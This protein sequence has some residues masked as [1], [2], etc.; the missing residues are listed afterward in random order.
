VRLIPT[1]GEE[2]LYSPFVAASG[3][4]NLFELAIHQ[5]CSFHNLTINERSAVSIRRL[6]QEGK[7]IHS[8][9]KKWLYSLTNDVEREVEWK[10]S[11]TLLDYYLSS[12]LVAEKM[13]L[14]VIEQFRDFVRKS[15]EPHE[16][17]LA[18]YVFKDCRVFEVRTTSFVEREGGVLKHH[19]IGPKP[20]HSIDKSLASI[21]NVDQL[22]SIQ[23]AQREA[24]EIE[25]LPI[26]EVK[27]ESNY[28]PLYEDLTDFAAAKLVD[29]FES[30]EVYTCYRVD[31]VTF[32]V[33]AQELGKFDHGLDSEEYYKSIIPRFE[34]TREVTLNRWKDS[35]YYLSCSCCHFQR[36]GISCGH[37]FCV[38]NELPHSH[39]VIIRWHLFYTRQY[40]RG[41]NC[42]DALID[43]A[44]DNE[45][46]GLLATN[47][48]QFR[49]DLDIGQCD[50]D[51]FPLEYFQRSLPTNHPV[52]HPGTFWGSN[53][54]TLPQSV[55]DLI[56]GAQSMAP[57]AGLNQYSRMTQVAQ[58]TQPQFSQSS[59]SI[60]D[61]STI[62]E[63]EEIFCAGLSNVDQAD[64][65]M[66][67]HCELELSAEAHEADLSMLSHKSDTEVEDLNH[68]RMS[69]EYVIQGYP[70]ALA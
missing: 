58:G 63:E 52:L 24:R 22:R 18:F 28:L 10:V 32:L 68:G 65:S 23:R 1:D 16:R 49:T 50:L 60:M 38:T 14:A 20:Q 31:A 69:G 19:A 25:K 53:I 56:S 42:V 54:S 21:N 3:P 17:K 48:L 29:Q 57:P 27:R 6:S 5:M 40:G 41:D 61:D 13:G 2:K 30:R 46:P 64:I 55:S 9:L 7:L 12:E 26:N 39:D 37:V 33:K 36:W 70:K 44:I 15:V 34:R 62:G 8:V 4:G 11:I 47:P 67:S 35:N 45:I 66:L 43:D 51:G 59:V